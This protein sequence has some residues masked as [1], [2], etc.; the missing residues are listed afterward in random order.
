MMRRDMIEGRDMAA[1]GTAPAE[2]VLNVTRGAGLQAPEEEADRVGHGTSTGV[3][4]VRDEA[5]RPTSKAEPN[6]LPLRRG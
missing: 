5:V 1:V 6:P 2:A 4:P 3:A